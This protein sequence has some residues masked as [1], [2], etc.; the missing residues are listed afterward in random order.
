[1]RVLVPSHHSLADQTPNFRQDASLGLVLGLAPQ[2]N[3][4]ILNEACLEA[5][6]FDYLA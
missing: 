5:A 3:P 6:I 2:A 1:M 4:K